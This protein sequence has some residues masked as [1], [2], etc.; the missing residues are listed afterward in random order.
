MNNDGRCMGDQEGD[1][2]KMD[3]TEISCEDGRWEG[4]A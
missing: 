4:L 1:N 3:L 2:I